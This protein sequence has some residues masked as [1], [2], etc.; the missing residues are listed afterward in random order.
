[1]K[2]NKQNNNI[3][4]LELLRSRWPSEIVPRRKVGEVSGGLLCP[5]TLANADCKGQG[6]ANAI[7]L[8]N[9]VAYLLPDLADYM[10]RR[11]LIIKPGKVDEG[12]NHE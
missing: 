6:P 7:R 11:G 1:M 2:N 12:K 3:D 10:L 4:L 9:R 8:G 5:G